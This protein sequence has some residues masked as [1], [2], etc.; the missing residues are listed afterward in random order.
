MKTNETN[1]KLTAGEWVQRNGKI[2]TVAC[3]DSC[4]HESGA[5]VGWSADGYASAWHI[6]GKICSVSESSLD[7]IKPYVEP[8]E[9]REY[10]L[11]DG[12][13]FESDIAAQQRCAVANIPIIHVIEVM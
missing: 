4:A 2:A 5:A 3:V 13:Y 12:I 11:C 9:P 10:W 7:L 8:Q 1:M 6:T